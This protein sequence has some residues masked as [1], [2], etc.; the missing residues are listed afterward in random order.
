MS[1]GNGSR[2]FR[3]RRRCFYVQPLRAYSRR[4]GQGTAASH[5]FTA[6]FWI[7][8]VDISVE[9]KLNKTKPRSR[10]APLED[11]TGSSSVP[12]GGK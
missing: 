8:F 5:P 1:Y 4:G 10:F 6:A 2:A 9:K 7:Y 11:K 3:R 12:L